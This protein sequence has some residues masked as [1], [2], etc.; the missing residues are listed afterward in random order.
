[1]LIVSQV[2]L[3]MRIAL[4]ATLA[5]SALWFVALR[6]KTPPAASTPAAAT[7]AQSTPGQGAP[8]Q[9]APGQAAQQANGA[10]EATQQAAGQ[11]EAAAGNAATPDAGTAARP[12]QAAEA[13]AAQPGAVDVKAAAAKTD[14]AAAKAVLADIEKR[15][16]V[17]L[18][19]WDRRVSDDRAVHTAVQGLSRRGGKVAVH[20][21][22]I[23]KLADY[24]AISRGVPV[25]TSPTVLIIDRARRARSVGGL[26]VPAELEELVGKALRVKP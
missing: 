13:G 22:P 16:V 8:A 23:A 1:M 25:V 20:V 9:S 18:L 11:A 10:V 19:F 5:F 3:P 6:P 14:S 2:S 15:K 4:V 17:V 26:T 12:A 21:A 24:E 7:P